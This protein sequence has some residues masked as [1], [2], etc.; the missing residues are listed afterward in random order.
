M[1]VCICVLGLGLG[2]QAA[3]SATAGQ[4]LVLGADYRGTRGT[5]AGGAAHDTRGRPGPGG[6]GAAGHAPHL[7]R[8]GRQSAA[9]RRGNRPRPELAVAGR[10]ARLPSGCRLVTE[11]G[12]RAIAQDPQWGKARHKERKPDRI[13]R[14]REGKVRWQMV[15]QGTK[16]YESPEEGHTQKQTVLAPRTKVRPSE[17]SLQT[18]KL[19]HHAL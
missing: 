16:G 2:L 14:D 9:V 17:E 3:A 12:A 1:L 6:A 11:G 7:A 18:E 8:E 15:V 13:R 5:G 19:T 10:R 4:G